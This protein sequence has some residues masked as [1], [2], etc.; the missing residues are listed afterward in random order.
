MTVDRRSS[1]FL[2]N[3]PVFAPWLDTPELPFNTPH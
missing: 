2:A 1:Q 3:F